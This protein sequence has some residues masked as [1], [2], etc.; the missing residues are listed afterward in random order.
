MGEAPE[1]VWAVRGAVQAERNDAESILAATGALM[2][3]LLARNGL[4]PAR[5]VSCFFTCTDDLDAEFP[6]VAA[7]E[8]GLD[9]VPLMC[10]R[11]MHVAGAMERVI[12]VLVHY[13]APADHV[14]ANVYLGAARELRT[15][16]TSAR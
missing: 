1:R 12:R 6:A 4:R 3:E 2:R 15:D 8:L 14:P 10:G 7:R 13:Y 11:E 9:R 5:I 16:L